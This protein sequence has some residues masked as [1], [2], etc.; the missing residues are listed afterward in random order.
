MFLAGLLLPIGTAPWVSLVLLQ[1]GLRP[2]TDLNSIC[3]WLWTWSPPV[4]IIGLL[5]EKYIFWHP[6]LHFSQAALCREDLSLAELEPAGD[7]VTKTNLQHSFG[8]CRAFAVRGICCWLWSGYCRATSLCYQ[9]PRQ[10]CSLGD[11]GET[12]PARS[13]QKTTSAAC[14]DSL[15]R[16]V[17]HLSVRGFII[18]FSI[19]LPLL[20]CRL[21]R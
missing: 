16:T 20:K 13:Q 6:S 15:P 9:A 21:Q 7:R 2:Q 12:G 11:G 14:V 19:L 10:C 3:A 1:Q 4:H 18:W 5:S 17:F 8:G